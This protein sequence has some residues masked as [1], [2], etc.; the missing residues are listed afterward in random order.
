MAVETTFLS[1]VSAFLSG[2][3]GVSPKPKVNMVEP[4][5]VAD[6]PA[7]VLSLERVERPSVGMGEGSSTR[8]GALA[9]P[10]KIDLASPFLPDDPGH[11]FSLLS[12]DRKQL[13]LPH[14]G[15]VHQDGT[16]D[17]PLSGTDLQ[18]KVAGIDRPVVSGT[19]T[20]L[21]VRPDAGT[22]VLTFATALPATGLAEANYFL[23][24]WERRVERLNGVLRLDVCAATSA[25][26]QAV[27]D[28]VLNALLDP[29]AR[30]G[31]P[32]LISISLQSL[33]SIGL[34]EAASANARRRQ[35]RLGFQYE[36]DV[37][38][39]ESAGGVIQRIPVTANVG[40]AG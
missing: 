23:G 1:A 21:Q 35:A 20:G 9:W 40:I 12:A 32:R 22:G 2:L 27:A 36:H 4:A 11:T 25:D 7:V 14:G 30:Q 24:Q 3:T 39:P 18:V 33:G 26:A 37:D 8:T 5:L 28:G 34:P 29:A 17:T 31:V 16:G 19:P 13:T 10:A 38:R 6:L 15:L